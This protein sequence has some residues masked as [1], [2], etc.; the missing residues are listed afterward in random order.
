MVADSAFSHEIDYLS[1]FKGNSKSRR[2]SKS[3]YWFKSYG[4]FVEFVDF[5]YWWSFIGKGL[6]LQSAQQA[7]SPE[8]SLN[9]RLSC[10]FHGGIFLM[11]YNW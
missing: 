6:R 9:A 11:N 2:A 5:A 3:H 4:D 7:C 1:F 8:I 10:I